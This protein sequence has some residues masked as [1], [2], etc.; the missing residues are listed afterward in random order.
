MVVRIRLA[1]FGAKHAAFFRIV[2]ANAR[3]PRDGRHIERV[4]GYNPKPTH[5]N[6][7]LVTLNVD[8]IKYWLSVGAQPSEPVA[9]LLGMAGILPPVPKRKIGTPSTVPKAERKEAS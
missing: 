8:R 4:G 9:R 6:H 3:S 1:R 5:D 7:K 2:V